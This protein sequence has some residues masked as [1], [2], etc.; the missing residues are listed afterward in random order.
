MVPQV[1]I[2]DKICATSRSKTGIK[3]EEVILHPG[4]GR[5]E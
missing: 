1:V 5:E 2:G 3:E 4:G